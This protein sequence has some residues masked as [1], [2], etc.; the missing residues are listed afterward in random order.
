MF[1]NL[2]LE[3][4]LWLQNLRVAGD[5]FLTP[6]FLYITKFGEYLIPILTCAVI[7]WC[8]DKKLGIFIILNSAATLM[9][10]HLFKNI[11]CIYRPWMLD[12]RIKPVEQA[13]R[14]AGGYSFPS[15]HVSLAVS[16]W[17]SIGLWYRKNIKLLISTVLICILVAFSRNYLG[18]HTLQ[19]VIIGLISACI[20]L[21]L[22]YKALNWC[23]QNSK[24][25][26]ILAVTISLIGIL[27]T[28]YTYFKSYPIDYDS[29]NNMLMDINRSKTGGIPKLGLLLGAFWGWYIETRF[30]DFDAKI[31]N[32]KTKIIRALIGIVLLFFIMQTA[33]LWKAYCGA[34]WGGFGFMITNG[35]FITLIY[36]WCVKIYTKK[37][38]LH[39]NR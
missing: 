36:P 3:Y 37:H 7:Y 4:L 33:L 24:R 18:V 6:L 21:V 2:Q 32:L 27:I 39:I 38:Y 16:C 25:R 13:L 1:M 12:S 10:N 28:V 20:M 11:A 5:D 26:L 30:I 8:V 35:L 19:D 22:L 17:G 31:G 9:L 29:T 15:G 34:V 23:D 14:F